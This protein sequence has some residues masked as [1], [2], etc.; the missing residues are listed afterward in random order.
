MVNANQIRI[1]REAVKQLYTELNSILNNVYIDGGDVFLEDRLLRQY[2]GDE[3]ED[4]KI[5]IKKIQEDGSFEV[6]GYEIHLHMYFSEISFIKRL[7]RNSSF[8]DI[9]NEMQDDRKEIMDTLYKLYQ[10]AV[11]VYNTVSEET[12]DEFERIIRESDYLKILRGMIK[13]EEQDKQREEQKEQ[14]KKQ[15]QTKKKPGRPKKNN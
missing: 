13:K 9:Y 14:K 1:T 8:E 15:N 6:G 10:K 5:V 4:D 2:S 7:M 3:Y 12:K 11:F